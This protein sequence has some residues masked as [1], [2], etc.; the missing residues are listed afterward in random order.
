MRYGHTVEVFIWAVTVLL[1]PFSCV[2][3]PLSAL[4]VWAQWVARGFPSMYLFEQMRAI[5][6]GTPTNPGDFMLSIGLNTVYLILSVVFF[7]GH[8]GMPKPMDF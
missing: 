3:Y 5:I 2:F 4:P 1:Q 7:T 8:S 6:S